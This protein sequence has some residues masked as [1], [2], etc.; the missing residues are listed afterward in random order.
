MVLFRLQQLFNCNSKEWIR[1]DH[2][3]AINYH[4]SHACIHPGPTPSWAKSNPS[5]TS[6]FR[7]TSH[8]GFRSNFPI[9]FLLSMSY[10]THAKK[11]CISWLDLIMYVCMYVCES[12]NMERKERGERGKGELLHLLKRRRTWPWH[13]HAFFFILRLQRRK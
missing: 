9:V 2:H 12:I 5:V 13:A 4:G 11:I 10:Y 3:H 8:H 7:R 1:V 6:P